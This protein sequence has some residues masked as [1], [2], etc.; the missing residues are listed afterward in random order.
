MLAIPTTEATMFKA[1]E[2][3]AVYSGR[4]GCAC[5]CRG[6]YTYRTPEARP[7]YMT[8]DEGVSPKGV[9]AMVKKVEAMVA[10]P[11]SEVERVEVYDDFVA[12][13]MNHDRTYTVYF[14]EAK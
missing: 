11:N 14:K 10:D 5:G 2:V 6:K 1:E 3:T 13:D 4:K 12:V 8:G 7:S 9:A